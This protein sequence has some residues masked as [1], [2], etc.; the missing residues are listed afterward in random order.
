MR[1]IIIAIPI[2]LAALAM[3]AVV[4]VIASWVLRP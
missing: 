2:A 1:D 3:W 4:F